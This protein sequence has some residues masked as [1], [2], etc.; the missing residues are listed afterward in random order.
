[1]PLGATVTPAGTNFAI[2]SRHATRVWLHLFGQPTD[3]TPTHTFELTPEAHRTGDIW[4]I[5][6]SN[7]EHGQLYLYRM[8]GPYDPRQGYRF[9]QYKP[10]L[11]PYAKALTGGFRW[12]FS[13]SFGYD[14]TLPDMDLSFSITTNFAGMPK[15]IVYGDDGFEWQGDLQA[16]DF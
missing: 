5:H 9:N 2:F 1:M 10:L 6:L 11:D 16:K 12:D 8:D 3:G 4:H 14:P 7:V 13:H 15:C